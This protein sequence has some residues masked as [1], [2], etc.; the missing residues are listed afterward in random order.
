MTDDCKTEDVVFVRHG[1]W[2]PQKLLGKNCLEG[3]E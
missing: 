1:K 2:L 3:W